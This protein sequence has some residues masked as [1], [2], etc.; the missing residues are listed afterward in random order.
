[1]SSSYFPDLRRSRCPRSFLS[2]LLPSVPRPVYTYIHTYIHIYQGLYIHT[3]IHTYI[4]TYIHTYIH[5]YVC[6]CVCVCVY[7]CMYIR[8]QV[9]KYIFMLILLQGLDRELVENC[10]RSEEAMDDAVV[11]YSTSAD[12]LSR[13]RRSTHEQPVASGAFMMPA[14][15]PNT[16]L[17]AARV[18]NALVSVR[19][20]MFRLDRMFKEQRE[21]QASA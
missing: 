20:R 1:V 15:M 12:L 4:R 16:N 5:A 13:F 3:Y 19:N 21:G 8:I 6:V 7:I 2:M 14:A 17:L 18:S 9:Y 10:R 11:E